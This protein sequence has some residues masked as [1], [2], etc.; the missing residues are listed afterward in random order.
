M[1]L[2]SLR[3]LALSGVALAA[4][5]TTLGTS[6]FAWY[7]TNSTATASGV[8]GTVQA[9]AGGNVLLAQN[10]TGSSAVS[11]TGSTGSHGAWSQTLS[12][13]NSNFSSTTTASGLLPATPIASAVASDAAATTATAVS[14]I[15]STTVWANKTGQA[16]AG[17]STSYITFD[18]W[19]QSTQAH[20]LNFTFTISNTTASNAIHPQLAMA[21]DGLPT[22]STIKQG[23]EFTVNAVNALRMSI[24]STDGHAYLGVASDQKTAGIYDVAASAQSTSAVATYANDDGNANQYYEAVLNDT[25]FI[26]TGPTLSEFDSKNLKLTFTNSGDVYQTITKLTFYIWLEGTD[27]GC[28]DSCNGQS[29]AVD[30]KF[31]A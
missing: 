3:K 20:E 31:A 5:A 13:L 21:N 24:E 8:E 7:I 19:V 16:Q 1:K 30:F 26:H 14:A 25:N 11:E 17:A 28:F 9:G 2:K 29:F 10:A 18:L 27:T 22:P 15:T 6:T 12:Y 4:A 23:Q